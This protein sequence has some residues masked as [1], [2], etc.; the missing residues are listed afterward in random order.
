MRH[1]EQRI[2]GAAPGAGGDGH[3]PRW[4]CCDFGE[5]DRLQPRGFIGRPVNRATGAY[6]SDA[7]R[8]HGGQ[9]RNT[10]FA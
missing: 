1:D 7:W 6:L 4:T 9:L 10:V 5:T 3:R 2:E 8:A